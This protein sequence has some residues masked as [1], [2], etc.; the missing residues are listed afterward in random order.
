MNEN[1]TTIIGI[2]AG[3]TGAIAVHKFGN[4]VIH[5]M[6]PDIHGIMD[7]L[8]N[9]TNPIIFIEAVNHFAFEDP[10]K[11]FG[12]QKMRDQYTTLKTVIEM[13]RIPRVELHARTWQKRLNIPTIKNEEYT[14]RKTRFWSIAQNMLPK[15]K[16]HKYAADS[17]LICLCGYNAVKYDM[18]FINQKIIK[19]G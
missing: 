15:Q 13:L 12:I 11:K 5:K 18:D 10:K 19:H 9:H 1:Y 7:V 2:D 14:A 16:V 8:S 4:T 6:P 17:V 3:K